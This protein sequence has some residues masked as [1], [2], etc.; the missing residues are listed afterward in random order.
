MEY[1]ISDASNV[2]HDSSNAHNITSVGL[3]AST[4]RSDF[5]DAHN[6]KS[7]DAI[8]FQHDSFFD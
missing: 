5:F 3:K 1:V 8:R 6:L 7:F 4:M 2:S